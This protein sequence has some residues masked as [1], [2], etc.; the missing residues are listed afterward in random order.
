ME[1]RLS[2]RVAALGTYAERTRE[3]EP[4]IDEEIYKLINIL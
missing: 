2:I 4:W 1:L 3:L